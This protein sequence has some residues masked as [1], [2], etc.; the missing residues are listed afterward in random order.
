VPKIRPEGFGVVVVQWGWCGAAAGPGS[1]WGPGAAAEEWGGE[2]QR[3][4]VAIPV[5]SCVCVPQFGDAEPG[6][7]CVCRLPHHFCPVAESSWS[8]LSSRPAL[9]QCPAAQRETFAGIGGKWC[10][11]FCFLEAIS[12]CPVATLLTSNSDRMRS[13]GLKLHQGRFRLDIRKNFFTERVVRRWNRPQWW[14]RH[15]WRCSKNI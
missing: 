14:S 10:Y 5:Q 15:L 9:P 3:M 11:P 4:L 12:S 13:N 1:A 8:P 6:I 7:F 2:G